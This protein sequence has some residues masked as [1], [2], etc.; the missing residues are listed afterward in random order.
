MRLLG[1]VAL[2]FCCV[3]PTVAQ[4][5]GPITSVAKEISGL[6]KFK[7][8]PKRI[9]LDR[10]AWQTADKTEDEKLQDDLQAMIK[11]GIPKEIAEKLMQRRKN[12]PRRAMLM[13]RRIEESPEG[14]LFEHLKI[15]LG[16]TGS[17]RSS[18]GLDQQFRGSGQNAN[19]TMELHGEEQDLVLTVKENKE[20]FQELQVQD[21]HRGGLRIMFLSQASQLLFSQTTTGT[22]RVSQITDSDELAFR[23]ESYEALVQRKPKF[24]REFRKFAE[25]VG[26]D[27]PYANHEP[28]IVEAIGKLLYKPDDATVESAKELVAQLG[29]ESYAARTEAE[30]K[31]RQQYDTIRTVLLQQMN[32]SRLEAEVKIRLRNITKSLEV[33]TSKADKH[34]VEQKLLDDIEYLEAIIAEAPG[35]FRTAIEERIA[36]LR[37]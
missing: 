19:V 24:A 21:D 16:C 28:E 13:R 20:P 3:V 34:V 36:A 27:L 5:N 17:G 18:S 22:I 30:E 12:D 8:G 31:I 35:A 1:K 29:A 4:E 10:D 2:I 11:R 7:A 32:D 37:R 23:C 25:Q 14:E 15:A 33:D 6:L 9:E 26:I